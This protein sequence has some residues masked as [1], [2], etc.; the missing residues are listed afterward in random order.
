MPLLYL[1][2][3]ANYSLMLP[4]D[5]A[6]LAA[7]IAFCLCAL[8]WRLLWRESY[9]RWRDAVQA[10]LRL[11]MFVS[12]SR[13]RLFQGLVAEG[14][15][16]G[17]A[18]QELGLRAYIRAATE[19]VWASLVPLLLLVP[20]VHPVMLWMHLPCQA[21]AVA[22]VLQHNAFV[23]SSP[24]MRGSSS[25]EAVAEALHGAMGYLVLL[26]PAPLLV[27]QRQ[28]LQGRAEAHIIHCTTT[29]GMLQLCLGLA[30]P[31]AVQALGETQRFAQVWARLQAQQGGRAH[32]GVTERLYAWL[33]TQ[34]SRLARWDVVA[35]FAVASWH[36]LILLC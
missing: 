9:T 13:W 25:V 15:A 28:E 22:R 7:S 36:L 31:V 17:V 20:F 11:S 1:A 12:D 3:R 27:P 8:A 23:C 5:R 14:Q 33:G 16:P 30:V 21:F 6:Y 35:L 24:T 32:M 18:A 19:L 10:T 29:L 34:I 2:V 4:V 26:S